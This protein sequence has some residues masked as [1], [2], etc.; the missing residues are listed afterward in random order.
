MFIH[1]AP[2]SSQPARQA[3]IQASIQ[4]VR[5]PL[6]EFTASSYEFEFGPRLINALCIIAKSFTTTTTKAREIV[7]KIG[8]ETGRG[9]LAGRDW[10]T[11]QPASTMGM[12][13]S[14]TESESSSSCTVS[15]GWVGE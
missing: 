3:S 1:G 9:R 5:H 15:L 13:C 11:I 10:E 2:L 7:G 6:I 8:G 4:P 14:D 12:R